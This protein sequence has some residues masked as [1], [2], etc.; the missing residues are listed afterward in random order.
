MNFLNLSAHNIRYVF[1]GVFNIVSNALN[2]QH[3]GAPIAQHQKVHVQ[4]STLGVFSVLFLHPCY[5][6]LL[7]FCYSLSTFLIFHHLWSCLG[8]FLLFTKLKSFPNQNTTPIKIFTKDIWI[9]ECLLGWY[10]IFGWC[11][12]KT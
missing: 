7:P 11:P 3:L 10:V 6:C 2:P 12:F 5:C 9:W 4:L 1:L 8:V